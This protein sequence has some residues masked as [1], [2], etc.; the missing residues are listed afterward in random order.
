MVMLGCP[1]DSSGKRIL[2]KL[3]ILVLSALKV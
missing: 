3:K 2:V 1:G